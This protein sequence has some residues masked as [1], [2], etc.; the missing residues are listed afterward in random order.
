MI[1]MVKNAPNRTITCSYGLENHFTKKINA[2]LKNCF[3]KAARD[4]KILL[5]LQNFSRSKIRLGQKVTIS[6]LCTSSI[7]SAV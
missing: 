7:R 3:E 5:A 1:E 6:S 2:K 4:Q